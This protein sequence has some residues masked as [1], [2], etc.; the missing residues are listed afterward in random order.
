MTESVDCLVRADLAGSCPPPPPPP[1]G[2]GSFHLLYMSLSS[3]AIVSKEL[4]PP[5][6]MPQKHVT[7]FVHFVPVACQRCR[8]FVGDPDTSLQQ[9]H[10]RQTPTYY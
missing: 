10:A 1:A 6:L 7:V 8:G 9:G 4:L 5:A 2:A 3:L